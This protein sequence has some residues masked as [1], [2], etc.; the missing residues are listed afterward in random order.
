MTAGVPKNLTSRLGDERYVS[1]TTFK[2]DGRGVASAM[3]AAND[4]P[5]IVI[6]TPSESWKVRRLRHD[7]RVTLQACTASG[8]V[9]AN[10]PELSGTAEIIAEP[11]EVARVAALI[12]S[13]YGW[14]F[15]VVTLLEAVIARGR[16]PRVALRITPS[17]AEPG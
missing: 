9:R 12:K 7:P 6:W 3:W 10:E 16:K 13:K 17:A 8:K 11:H 2:R 15:R 1:L 4:G 5:H 14:A